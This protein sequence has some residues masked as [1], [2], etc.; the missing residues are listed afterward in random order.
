MTLEELL[1]L[2][3]VPGQTFTKAEHFATDMENK[4]RAENGLPLRTHYAIDGR[5]GSGIYPLIDASGNSL[6]NGG[7]NYY[8]RLKI[9]PKRILLPAAR[10]PETLK[11]R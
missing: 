11:P 10:N 9:T 6:H 2:S 1:D 4:L 3:R 8:G 5:T 7:H